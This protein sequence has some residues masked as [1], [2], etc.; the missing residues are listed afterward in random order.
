MAYVPFT[1][2]AEVSRPYRVG[3]LESVKTY[4]AKLQGEAEQLRL[5]LILRILQ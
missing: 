3:Y 1:E 4:L 2:D 5:P